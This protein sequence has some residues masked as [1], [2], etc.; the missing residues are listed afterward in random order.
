MYKLKEVGV[1]R[2]YDE[3]HIPADPGNRDWQEYQA[4]LAA[5]NTPQPEFTQEEIAAKEEA[6]AAKMA[7]LVDIEELRSDYGLSGLKG[8]KI[9]ELKSAVKDQLSKAGGVN[10][11]IEQL[12]IA[13]AL[14]ER[15]LY[16]KL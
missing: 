8:L 2:M 13:V 1:V 11:A 7:E 10:K 5:G 6:E 15:K 4:W 14:L 9:K 12:A 16:G 3:A